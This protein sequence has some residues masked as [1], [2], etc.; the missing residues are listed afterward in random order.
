MSFCYLSHLYIVYISFIYLHILLN[1]L[2]LLILS[3]LL[4]LRSIKN[5]KNKLLFNLHL[6]LL[7]LS[8][9]ISNADTNFLTYSISFS[10][11]NF[12][13]FLQDRPA[14]NTFLSRHCF[15]F[16]FLFLSFFSF[17]HPHYTYVTALII[18]PP[19]LG[20]SVLSFS[21]FFLFPFQFWRFLL[22]YS[23]T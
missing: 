12:Q 13:H 14:G 6:S 19:V 21:I 22:K 9:C 15:R 16:F 18:A 4:S 20:S 1:T 5:Q 8:S 3:E 7:H 17:R 11:K 23:Q 10:L 2:L